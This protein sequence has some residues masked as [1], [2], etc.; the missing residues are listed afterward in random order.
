MDVHSYYSITPNQRSNEEYVLSP[1]SGASS[2][3]TPVVVYDTIYID[4][5]SQIDNHVHHHQPV[6]VGLSLRYRIND[7]WSIESG[8]T[9]SH[10]SSDITTSVDEKTIATTEQRLD[11]LGIPV[12][13]SYQLWGARYFNFY[14]SAGGMVEKMVKGRQ[15]TYGKTASVSIRPL[16]LSLN[17]AAGVEFRFF[18]D[19]SLY[20][21]PALGYY[22]DNGSRIS[23]YYQEKPFN[24]N[25]NVGLRFS[26]NR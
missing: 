16:Q 20:A 22:F 13:A 6:H 24:F 8:L 9:Y 4:K 19:F 26:L 1:H 14:L 10:H 5:Y 7:R 3:N 12:S 18:K 21:E 23:T 17:G 15:T 2:S 25:I 11:Y